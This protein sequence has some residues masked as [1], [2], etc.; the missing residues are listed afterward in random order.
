MLALL[1][2]EGQT[3]NEIERRLKRF[4]CQLLSPLGTGD[5]CQS[6]LECRCGEF[7]SRR[8]FCQPA[9]CDLAQPGVCATYPGLNHK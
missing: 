2:P 8:G 4:S 5:S 9:T 3:R 6:S 1:P 7:C